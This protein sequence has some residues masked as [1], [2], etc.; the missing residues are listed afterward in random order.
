M[1][2]TK[3]IKISQRVVCHKYVEVLIHI[4]I[5]TLDEYVDDW[6][7][8]N[9]AMVDVKLENALHK[10]PFEG[11]SGFYDYEGMDTLDDVETRFDVVGNGYGGHL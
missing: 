11:G 5:S 9:Q 6:I 1:E 7:E 3:L 8:D 2:K 10:Q 4:P